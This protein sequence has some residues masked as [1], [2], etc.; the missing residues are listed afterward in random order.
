[1]SKWTLSQLEEIAENAI[2]LDLDTVADALEDA[3]Q[4]IKDLRAIIAGPACATPTTTTPG[5]EI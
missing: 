5:K 1:M 4:T 2:D 3:I